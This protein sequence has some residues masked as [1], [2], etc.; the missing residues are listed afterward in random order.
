MYSHVQANQ[1]WKRENSV[2]GGE[3][4]ALPAVQNF[5]FFFEMIIFIVFWIEK[6][7]PNTRI[8]AICPGALFFL[9]AG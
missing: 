9:K 3:Y 4:L 8:Q 6:S 5:F 2:R 1:S 7:K